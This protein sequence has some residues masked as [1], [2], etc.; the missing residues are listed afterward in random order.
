MTFEKGL[1]SE[2]SCLHALFGFF[3][4]ALICQNVGKAPIDLR[5]TYRHHGPEEF[6]RLVEVSFSR[7]NL[8]QMHSRFCVHWHARS[9]LPNGRWRTHRAPLS[10]CCA[11]RVAYGASVRLANAVPV[12]HPQLD[13]RS[14]SRVLSR[15]V[16]PPQ[17]RLG[18]SH[19]HLWNR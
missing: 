5:I 3:K 2:M 11:S 12:P 15:S 4:L 8:C 10:C 14:G 7:A 16:V 6:L 18:A 17:P 9:E 19:D 13:W 1:E